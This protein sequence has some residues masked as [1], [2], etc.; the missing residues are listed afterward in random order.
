MSTVKRVDKRT[1]RSRQTRAKIVAAAR[2]LFL[3]HGY[4]ATNLQDVAER[5]GVA[6]QTI[7]F[8]FR[9][10][11]ALLKELVDTTIAGDDEPV[12]TMDRPWF[13]EAC[14]APTA[15]DQLRQHV[16]GTRLILDRVAP[17]TKLLEAAAANDPEIATMWPAEEDP[18]FT[19]QSAA[20]QALVAKPGAR[21]ELSAAMA[22]DLLYCLLSP[23][24]YLVF[25]RDRGW[26]PAQWETWAYETLHTQLCEGPARSTSSRRGSE[27]TVHAS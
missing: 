22:A 20:A 7:Y 23:D 25:V 24:L 26:S 12:A 27:G 21:P 16:H 14:A 5:A 17:I 1:E 3:E 8:V 11:R 6:V 13:R 15:A 4:G 10:K 2:E 19:V 18:R 9:N